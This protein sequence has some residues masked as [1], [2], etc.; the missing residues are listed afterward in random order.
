MF[1]YFVGRFDYCGRCWCWSWL[2]LLY[3]YALF[4]LLGYSSV[5]AWEA[6][7]Y[8]ATLV[9]VIQM[10]HYLR[11]VG[12]KRRCRRCLRQTLETDF[13]SSRESLGTCFPGL[14]MLDIPLIEAVRSS[15]SNSEASKSSI[16]CISSLS[17]I[18]VV[19]PKFNSWSGPQS[20]SLAPKSCPFGTKLL[21]GYS[22]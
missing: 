8:E 20:V 11:C 19:D 17:S 9:W 13:V 5:K 7:V 1:F 14:E 22:A 16:S 15:T 10:D 2:L 21:F 12:G 6:G 18:V 3:L 4:L